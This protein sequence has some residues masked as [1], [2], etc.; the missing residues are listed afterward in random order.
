MVGF[1]EIEREREI[2]RKAILLLLL[3][4]ISEIK[5]ERKKKRRAVVIYY[6]VLAIYMLK[7]KK[8]KIRQDS[9]AGSYSCGEA[10]VAAA[11][12]CYRNSTRREN[13]SIR[14]YP[15]KTL[16]YQIPHVLLPS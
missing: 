8:I 7:T 3:Q 10:E 5:K 14:C 9:S 13:N 2:K 12:D 11:C 4:V 15:L 6:E 16:Q 1:F